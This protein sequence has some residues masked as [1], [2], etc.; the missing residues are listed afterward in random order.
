MVN[1]CES[2]KSDGLNFMKL[3]RHTLS[4][5]FPNSFEKERDKGKRRKPV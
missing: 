1:D 3:I 2:I 5:V 4:Y